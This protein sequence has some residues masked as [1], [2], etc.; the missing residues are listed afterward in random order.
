MTARY[1]V[2]VSDLDSSIADTMHRWHLVPKVNPESSWEIFAAACPDDTPVPGT[3]T[4]LR[5]HH[6]VAR[7]HIVTG[8]SDTARPQTE[9]WLK[10][11]SVPCDEL[12][13]WTPD[14]STHNGTYKVAYLT[15]L[16]ERGF[17]VVLCYED[18]PESAAYITEHT[19][20]PVLGINPFYPEG[21]DL[22]L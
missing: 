10:R 15:E 7:V 14:C 12:R 21:R 6:A 13:M 1:D 3:I 2:V 16:K 20:I 4:S 19:G 22:P 8:R 11:H 5:L 9:K 18:W 17:N